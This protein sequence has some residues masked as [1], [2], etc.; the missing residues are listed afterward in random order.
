[1][2]KKMHN[3]CTFSMNRLFHVDVL[4]EIHLANIT[5][6]YIIDILITANYNNSTETE[7][8]KKKCCCSNLKITMK[9]RKTNMSSTRGCKYVPGYSF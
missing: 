8:K 3:F 2:S 5:M 6:F 1:M 7:F 4:L 9:I